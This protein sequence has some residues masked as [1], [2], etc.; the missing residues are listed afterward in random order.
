M[1]KWIR[2]SGLSIKKSLSKVG[3]WRQF[4]S[5]APWDTGDWS[6]GCV[7]PHTAGYV[8]FVPLDSEGNVTKFA[9]DKALKSNA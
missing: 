6:Q 3:W 2:T 4:R 9:P 5:A 7:P 8:G 1:I